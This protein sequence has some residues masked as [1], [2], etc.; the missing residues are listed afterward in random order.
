MELGRA[1]ISVWVTQMSLKV[2]LAQ[3]ATLLPGAVLEPHRKRMEQ[4]TKGLL[5]SPRFP[6]GVQDFIRLRG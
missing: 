6:K 2:A 3:F 4:R 1:T 5:I